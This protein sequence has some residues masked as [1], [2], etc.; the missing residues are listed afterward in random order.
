[1]DGICWVEAPV[2]SAEGEAEGEEEAAGVLDAVE[3]EA[4][5]PVGVEDA[6]EELGVELELEEA[7][8]GEA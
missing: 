3:V 7:G 4:E 8:E 6:D 5:F 2:E 1:M